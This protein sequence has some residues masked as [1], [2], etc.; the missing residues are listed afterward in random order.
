MLKRMWGFVPLLLLV[1]CVHKYAVPPLPVAEP[2]LPATASV[3]VVTPRDGQDDR[4]RTYAGSG[5]WTRSAIEAAL[6]QRGMKVV[7]GGKADSPQEFLARAAE[8]GADLV[9]DCQIVHWSDR[10]TEWSGIPDRIT[11]D[12]SVYDVET[13][14]AL[15]RQ[16]VRAS[17]R[18]ATLGGDH[19][20]ELLP[21]LTRRWAA[22]VVD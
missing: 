16:Q 4:P 22:T 21:E 10:V 20:Q 12:L 3:Y 14:A 11:L 6:R 13:G 1:S 8:A 19:P 9:V 15:N 17:S 2:L 5:D 7:G 18:W